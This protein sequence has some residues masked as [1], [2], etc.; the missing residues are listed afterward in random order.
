MA[1]Q[2]YYSSKSTKLLPS[3]GDHTLFYRHRNGRNIVLIVYVDD[4]ILTGDDVV[5]GGRLKKIDL[6]QNLK[7]RILE[8][9]GIF[10]E[11]K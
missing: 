9:L 7:W 3:R 11:W 5:E 6:Q 1:W 8:F 2:I 10:L 4:I